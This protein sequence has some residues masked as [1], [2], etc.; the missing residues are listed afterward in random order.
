M[1]A[2][3]EELAWCFVN[4]GDLT[5]GRDL[6]EEVVEVRDRRAEELEGKED[7]E[8]FARARAWWRLG[9]TEWR[10]GGTSPSHI[11]GSR[12]MIRRGKQG[13]CRELVHGFHASPTYI[14]ACLLG[15]RSVLRF[16]NSSR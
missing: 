3:K 9:Q 11:S 10:I 8:A 4:E 2:A 16:S 13:T 12:L 1:V 15:P 14:C 7:E 5:K 6:L